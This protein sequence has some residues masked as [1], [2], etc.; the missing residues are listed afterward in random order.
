VDSVSKAFYENG[1]RGIHVEATSTYANM[2]REDR[3]DELVLQVALSDA[4]GTLHFY[5]IPETGLS[6]GDKDIAQNHQSQGLQ[7]HETIVPCLTLIDVFEHAGKRDIHW[8]KIDVEGMERQVLAGWGKSTVRPWVLVIESTHPNSQVETHHTWEKFVIERGYQEAYH[9]GLNR[10]YVLIEQS[11]IAQCIGI[12]PNIFDG[13]SLA[14]NAPYV[15]PLRTLIVQAE[16][17]LRDAAT[18][19]NESLV[20][21]N[22]LKNETVRL[23][24]EAKQHEKK[25]A[26][27]VEREGRQFQAKLQ[28]RKKAAVKAALTATCAREEREQLMHAHAR[29]EREIYAELHDVKECATN[30]K[31]KVLKIHATEVATLRQKIFDLEYEAQS[32][33]NVHL[34]LMQQ[35]T[36]ELDIKEKNITM[37]LQNHA[38]VEAKLYGDIDILQQVLNRYSHDLTEA[39]KT[40]DLLANTLE[41]S[42]KL[43]DQHAVELAQGQ[44]F[45]GVIADSVKSAKNLQEL[46]SHHDE[47][48][49]HCAYKTLLRRNPDQEG[50]NYYLALVR[51]GHSK[52]HILTQLYLSN[53]CKRRISTSPSF[54]IGT[55]KYA[56]LRYPIV[57]RL[58]LNIGRW[59][60]HSETKNRFRAIENQIACLAFSMRPSK[61]D[62]THIDVLSKELSN[63]RESLKTRISMISAIQ[64]APNTLST[65]SK[66]TAENSSVDHDATMRVKQL[67]DSGVP[68]K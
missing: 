27:L 41:N 2:L 37:K 23:K 51:A 42:R 58:L 16:K 35:H 63:L 10:Y 56:W 12:P 33:K 6:T 36:S 46:L 55:K 59:F 45:H 44:Q 67:I 34:L 5:E 66:S 53:E 18:H 62:H 21:L 64:T 68:R 9:D 1:W 32:L 15:A 29:R 48:F 26:D 52:K 11:E 39:R 50:L 19:E 24:I 47:E 22:N 17:Q 7:V 61:P 40:I 4:T 3:P 38:T 31:I 65:T 8:L 30:W 43:C 49:V 57:G 54:A 28:E 14:Q 13:F 20:Q 25:L 60:D